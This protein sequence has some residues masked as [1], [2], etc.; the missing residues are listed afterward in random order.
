MSNKRLYKSTVNCMLCGVCGGIAEYFDIDPTLVRLAWVILTC[1]GGAGIWAY[2]IAAIIIF[3]IFADSDTKP[4]ANKKGNTNTDSR[5]HC[6]VNRTGSYS[7]ILNQMEQI[8][9]LI[10]QRCPW[11]KLQVLV[12]VRK[13]NASTCSVSFQIEDVSL[14]KNNITFGS[15]FQDRGDGS[16]ECMHFETKQATGFTTP[17]AV[18]RE[19]L[20]QFNWSQISTNI[21]EL[22]VLN[23]GA[24]THT[25]MV[26]LRF[27][28]QYRD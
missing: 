13:I 14:K 28:A 10:A 21:T 19:M 7:S 15:E 22:T 3:I 20:C 9:F 12:M 27:E 24:F 17:E 23:Y 8:V 2:I 1:F 25:P 11:M 6:T 5:L 4:S 18:K 26:T 16:Y